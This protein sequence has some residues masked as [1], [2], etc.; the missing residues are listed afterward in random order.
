MLLLNGKIFDASSKVED[1]MV[2]ARAH[3]LECVKYLRDK[4]K[5]YGHIKLVRRKG[6][7]INPSGLYEPTPMII[8]PAKIHT[9]VQFATKATTRDR[10]AYGG[11]ETW[12]Y[13]AESPIKKDGEYI[14]VPKSLKNATYEWPL[15]LE[16]DIE[17]IYFLLYKSPM[18]Y[19]PDAINKYGKRK[20]GELIIDDKDEREAR[21]ADG[22]KAA[23]KLNTAIY[24]DQ[25]SP[26]YDVS[27]LRSAA[28]A[29]G[30][31]GVLTD[32]VTEDE[33]R[34]LLYADVEQKQKVKE[35]TGV[36]KG[37]EDFLDFLNYDDMIRSRALVLDAI[38]RKIVLWDA[39]K[40]TY[41]YG[42]TNVPLMIVPEKNKHRKF[43]ALCDFLLAPTNNAAWEKFRKEVINPEVIKGKTFPW[44]KWLAGIEEIPVASK[45]EKDLRQA[46]V[47]RYS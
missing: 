34:N 26:L 4:F 36:G 40:F 27:A 22:R 28:A 14:C 2:A 37:V 7:K 9:S 16:K 8:W 17:L 25:T 15:D 6:L 39:V 45:S 1:D 21:I 46:L 33:V 19:F 42:S 10:D 12:A 5:N 38:D 30:V 43:D 47:E 32:A 29:W 24:G 3:Y 35:N 20:S 23:A 44:V 11:M 13:S 41:V 31:E 18:V